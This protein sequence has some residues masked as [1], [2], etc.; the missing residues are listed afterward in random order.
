MAELADALDSGSSARKGVRVQIP[1]SAPPPSQA[2]AAAFLPSV[3]DCQTITGYTSILA[4]E[5]DTDPLVNQR[6]DHYVAIL[7]QPSDSLDLVLVMGFVKEQELGRARTAN[8]V[9][10]GLRRMLTAV[11]VV[12]PGAELDVNKEFPEFRVTVGFQYSFE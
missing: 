8:L 10:V 11:S 12:S 3:A 9:E 5:H 7:G 2:P 1:P 6:T 4:W